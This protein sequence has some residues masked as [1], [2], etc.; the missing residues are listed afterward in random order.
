MRI[1]GKALMPFIP[2]V[3]IANGIIVEYNLLAWMQPGFKKR[4]SK[5]T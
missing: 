2:S 4:F 5:T 1:Y 3:G